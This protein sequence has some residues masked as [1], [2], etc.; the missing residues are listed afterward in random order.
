MSLVEIVETVINKSMD[1]L[2]SEIEG[3]MK[4]IVGNHSRSGVALGSIHIE[5]GGHTRRIGGSNLHLFFLDQG[6]NQTV[7]VIYPVSAKALRF[8]DGTF[9]KKANTYNGIHFV[10]EVANRHR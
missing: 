1:E 9:H 4:A 2:A 10:R 3:E 5:N 7:N 8:T 6:N